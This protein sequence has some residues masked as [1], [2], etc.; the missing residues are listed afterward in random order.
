[1]GV[2]SAQ[3]PLHLQLDWRYATVWPLCNWSPIRMFRCSGNSSQSS[4]STFI[5][6]L[7][8]IQQADPAWEAAWLIQLGQVGVCC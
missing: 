2:G 5:S 8:V 7:D 6:L 1:M 4:Q 3:R